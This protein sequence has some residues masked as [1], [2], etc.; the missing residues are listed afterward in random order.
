MAHWSQFGCAAAEKEK[1]YNIG[2]TEAFSI[3]QN[4]QWLHR[5]LNHFFTFYSFQNPHSLTFRLSSDTGSAQRSCWVPRSGDQNG[6]VTLLS[7]TRTFIKT[8]THLVAS[9][10]GFI[11]CERWWKFNTLIVFFFII[12]KPKQF[13]FPY[14]KYLLGEKLNRRNCFVF[15][16]FCSSRNF[17]ELLGPKFVFDIQQFA[18]KHNCPRLAD[19]RESCLRS[20]LKLSASS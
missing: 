2:S 15:N 11:Q 4:Y 1:I 10:T 12:K 20:A 9:K 8:K 16:I 6:E 17:V 14:S 18:L 3:L 19:E 7:S 5:F 13:L